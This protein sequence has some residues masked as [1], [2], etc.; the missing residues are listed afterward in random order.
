M[1][2]AQFAAAQGGVAYL[3]RVLAETGQDASRLEPVSAAAFTGVNRWGAPLDGVLRTAVIRSKQAV[4]EGLAP[5]SALKQGRKFLD[6]AVPSLLADANRGAVQA[7]ITSAGIAGYVRMLNGSSCHRCIILAGKWFRW[8]K[9]FQRHPLCDCRHIPASESMA[10]DLTT[11][12]YTAFTVMSI[13]EQDRTWGKRNAQAIRD[14][15]DIYRVSNVKTRGLTSER[16][17]QRFGTPSKMTL[18]DIYKEAGSSRTKATQLMRREGYIVGS[19]ELR[20]QAER[21]SKPISRPIVPGSARD[22]VLRARATGVRDQLD[23]ATMT[24]QERRLFD[25][26]YRL[27]YARRNGSIPRSIGPNSAD[28]AA[29]ARGLPLNRDRLE[30]LESALQRQIAAIDVARPESGD[31]LRLVDAL[32]LNDDRADIV[33]ERIWRRLNARF[34]AT[35][36]SRLSLAD[37]LHRL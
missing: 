4:G 36:G 29:N 10:G 12:P 6:T 37:A 14:G 1:T 18:D 22:R 32:G 9:G 35:N 3:P 20:Q 16:S 17:A 26:T 13:E 24:A 34:A 21:F 19:Q 30:L 15:A 7:G 25:A 28:V 8:N 5:A 11:D 2:R 27:E 31:L 23:R 33:H